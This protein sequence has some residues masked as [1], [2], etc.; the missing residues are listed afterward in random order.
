MSIPFLAIAL[1]KGVGS[2]VHMASHLGN[3]SQGAAA[4]AAGEAATGNYSFGNISEGNQQIANTSMLTQSRAASYRAG[5]FQ[6]VDGRTDMT[7]MGDGSQVANIGTSNLPVSPNVAESQSAQ[8]SEMAAKSS[9]KGVNLSK[10]SAKHLASSYRDMVNLSEHLGHSQSMN[11]GM[12]QGISAE[13]SKDIQKGTQLIQKFAKDNNISVEKAAEA[14]ATVS[15]G[16]DGF[17]VSGAMKAST[18]SA[19]REM[20]QNAAEFAN[21]ENF[22]EAMKA[23]SQ[24]SKNISHNLSDEESR[25]LAIDVSGSYET[26]MHERSEAAKSFSQSDSW[27]QQAMNTRANAASIN[28][29]Y[30]QQFLEWLADQPA[31]HTDGHIGH[32]GAAYIIANNPSE[33]MAYANK[34]MAQQGLIPQASLHTNPNQLQS[35]YQTERGHQKYEATQDSL[36]EVKGQGINSAYQ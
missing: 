24:A 21:N 6:F 20:Y 7:M 28:A 19:D 30:N 33:A 34:F 12:S 8:Q 23:A 11:D 1:V 22:H 31:D 3:V 14:L 13:Q 4:Q 25:K 18:S 27:S 10:N 17:F 29:N 15:I 2:F 26:G 35:D 9:Q 36:I 16:K 32:R 5:A